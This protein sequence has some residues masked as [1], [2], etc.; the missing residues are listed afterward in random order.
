MKN[1]QELKIEIKLHNN[2]PSELFLL[3]SDF[4][5]TSKMLIEKLKHKLTL[6]FEDQP[7]FK[8]VLFS[9]ISTKPKRYS[10]IYKRMKVIC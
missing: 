1:F 6:K 5:Y 10:S 4:E 7:N 2:F 8:I 9:G 3:T